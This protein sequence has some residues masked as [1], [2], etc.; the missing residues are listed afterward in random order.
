MRISTTKTFLPLLSQFHPIPLFQGNFADFLGSQCPFCCANSPPF[1][2]PSPHFPPISPPPPPIL[3]FPLGRCF[4]HPRFPPFSLVL[5]RRLHRLRCL[6]QDQGHEAPLGD[7]QAEALGPGAVP[8][9]ALH[10]PADVVL[11]ASRLSAKWAGWSRFWQSFG[12]FL[13]PSLVILVMLVVSVLLL[14]TRIHQPLIEMDACPIGFGGDSDH[15]WKQTPILTND[16][17]STPTKGCLTYYAEAVLKQ[18]AT[19]NG[20]SSLDSA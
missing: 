16:P 17:G 14:L 20:L 6:V 15:F 8:R 13:L 3:P 4:S 11:L 1:F 7:L 12:G 10:A 2:V 5:H 9:D 18:K 19:N